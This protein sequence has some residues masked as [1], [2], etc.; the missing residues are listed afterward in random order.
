MTNI[1]TLSVLVALVSFTV[2]EKLRDVSAA[3]IGAVKV[4]FWAVGSSNAT[5]GPAVCVQ[6]YVN[7][8]PSGSELALPSRITSSVPSFTVWLGPAL[9]TGGWLVFCT[10]MLTVSLEAPPFPSPTVSLKVRTAP[11]EPT[12]GAVNVGVAELAPD[13]VTDGPAVC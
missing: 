6:E 10:L 2:S 1:V 8:S 5:A 3:I 13:N 12:S 7:E 4:G 11:P 9:A